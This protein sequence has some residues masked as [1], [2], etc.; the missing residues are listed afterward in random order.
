MKPISSTRDT[1]YREQG[2]KADL[3]WISCSRHCRSSR[4]QIFLS[5][6]LLRTPLRKKLVVGLKI[7]ARESRVVEREW[8]RRRRKRRPEERSISEP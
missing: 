1:K 4:R 8:W 6:E 5:S 2:N 7:P 3:V